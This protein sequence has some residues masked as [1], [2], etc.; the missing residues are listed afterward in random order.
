MQELTCSSSRR[1]VN[2]KILSDNSKQM[3]VD[4]PVTLILVKLNKH[5]LI[6][7]YSSVS[8]IVFYSTVVLIKVTKRNILS[9]VLSSA[10]Q[11]P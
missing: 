4:T 3:L 2:E 9:R 1:Q 5:R 6:Y 8:F 10:I 11:I 7:L